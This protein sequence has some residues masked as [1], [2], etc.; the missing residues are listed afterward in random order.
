MSLVVPILS[1]MIGRKGVKRWI[2]PKKSS[3]QSLQQKDAHPVEGYY[4]Q[5][6]GARE[7]T[8]CPK[9]CFRR[10]SGCGFGIMM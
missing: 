2:F 5:V 7:R 9:G 10:K 3:L 1:S 8:V 6:Q 4:F